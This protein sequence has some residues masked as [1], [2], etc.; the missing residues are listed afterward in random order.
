MKKRFGFAL[1]LGMLAI[2]AMQA[3]QDNTGSTSLPRAERNYNQMQPGD[4]AGRRF[5][6][7]IPPADVKRIIVLSE[8][9]N[10]LRG[11]DDLTQRD[12]DATIAEL[13]ASEVKAK[14][15][16]RDDMEGKLA[17][18]ILLTKA[19]QV[20]RLE[21]LGKLGTSISAVTLNGPGKGVRLEVNE[22]QS[23]HR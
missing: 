13:M 2:P 3:R 11:K 18:I 19:G 4:W 10:S 8:S 9:S 22:S 20:Y 6:D 7:I 21:I 12:Y 5:R 16:S 14:E 23:Q 15:V 17:T 1:L